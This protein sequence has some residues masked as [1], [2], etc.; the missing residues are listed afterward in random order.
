[1]TG[2]TGQVGRLVVERLRT[3]GEKVRAVTRGSVE[4]GV[5][6]VRGD[7]R[8]PDSLVGAF[9]GADRLYL[10]P[11]AETAREVVDLARRAGIERIVVL[12]SGAVTTGHDTDFHLPVE[13]AVE[14]SGLE[15][16]HVRPGA[17]AMNSL[18]LWGPSVRAG[19][20]VIDPYPD[21]VDQPV[22]EADIADI[23]AAALLEDGHNGVAYTFVGPEQLSHRDQVAALEA[24]IGEPIQLPEVT[25]EQALE[26]YRRQGGWAAASAEF[27]FGGQPYSAEPG[28]PQPFVPRPSEFRAR[29]YAEWARGHADDFR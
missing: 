28:E 21:Q 17:F 7:L 3:A 18:H 8:E 13:Q 2:A 24:A 10:F 16:T 25:A 6:T 26:H 14:A 29:T 11:V 19:R 27:L 1:M 9:E 5:E 23:A 12:S 20:T 22:H 15:W 4:P